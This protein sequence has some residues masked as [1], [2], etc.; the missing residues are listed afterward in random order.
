[1]ARARPERAVE[2][3][4]HEELQPDSFAAGAQRFKPL[5]LLG[6]EAG[7]GFGGVDGRLVAVAR[8]RAPPGRWLGGCSCRGLACWNDLERGR[9]GSGRSMVAGPLS[10]RRR[11]R[12]CGA[13]PLYAT[14]GAPAAAAPPLLKD[15]SEMLCPLL[16]QL[17]MQR[18]LVPAPLLLPPPLL[19]LL[20]L[21]LMMLTPTW[22]G[23]RRGCCLGTAASIPAGRPL[24]LLL[25]PVRRLLGLWLLPGR[26]SAAP[27]AGAP[28][29]LPARVHAGAPVSR[30]RV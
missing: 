10:T 22:S 19:L 18:L 5:S 23:Y 1:M 9:G 27:L 25:V 13:L 21:L 29:L 12:L 16:L 8:E 26:P 20:L 14:A 15:R 17:W 6:V 24:A 4:L 3:H 28:A 2:A 7:D 11:G 30:Q